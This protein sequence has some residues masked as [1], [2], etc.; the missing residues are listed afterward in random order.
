MTTRSAQQ[1]RNTKIFVINAHTMQVDETT[2]FDHVSELAEETTSPRGVMHKL[3]IEEKNG[4]VYQQIGSN[5]II[6]ESEYENLFE[7]D[8]EDYQYYGEA[9]I[10]WEVR[11]WEPNGRSRIIETYETEEE[12]KDEWYT[13]TYNYDFIPDDQRDTRYW[14]TREEAA[15]ALQEMIDEQ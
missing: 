2:L 5:K 8:C 11:Q 10:A 12:A 14:N 1:A 15:Q 7:E 6:T 4:I 13:R 3:F 9:A